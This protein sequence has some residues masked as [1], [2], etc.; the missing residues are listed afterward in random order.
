MTSW[1]RPSAG[2]SKH[3]SSLILGIPIYTSKPMSSRSQS[4]SDKVLPGEGLTFDDLLLLPCYTDFKRAD[5]DL[6]THLHPSIV[7]PLPVIS[8]PMDTVTEE[9]MAIAMARTGGLGIIHRN[10]NVADQAKM[11]KA[12]K[13]ASPKN[14]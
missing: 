14:T 4:V 1:T 11:V 3:R 7:L 9:D 8:S 10:I 5:V 13:S 6:T 12:V 2:H